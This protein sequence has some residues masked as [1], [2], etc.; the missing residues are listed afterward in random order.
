M[1]VIRTHP[2]AFSKDGPAKLDDGDGL[3]S[4]PGTTVS[5]SISGSTGQTCA[6]E[7]AQDQPEITYYGD[8]YPAAWASSVAM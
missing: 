5:V 4:L 6:N 1:D 7:R 3:R 2:Q 8:L